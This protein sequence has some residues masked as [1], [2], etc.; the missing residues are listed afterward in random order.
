MNRHRCFIC[1]DECDRYKKRNVCCHDCTTEILKIQKSLR[2]NSRNRKHDKYRE[3]NRCE[4]FKMDKLKF[5]LIC[6]VTSSIYEWFH[7]HN[8][9]YIAYK[10][11][12]NNLINIFYKD[13]CADPYHYDPYQNIIYCN[14]MPC[15]L[16]FKTMQQVNLQNGKKINIIN[17]VIGNNGQY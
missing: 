5:D 1:L 2:R 14:K 13:Y 9:V 6:Y 10:Y 17:K 11:S 12:V 15:I 3:H 8:N 16:D 4:L 7:M